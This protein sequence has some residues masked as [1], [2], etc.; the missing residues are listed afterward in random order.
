MRIAIL[1]V[2]LSLAACASALPPTET[3]PPAAP[4]AAD[5]AALFPGVD[6]NATAACVREN[7]TEGELAIMSLGDQRSQTVTA[8][9]LGRPATIACLDRAGVQLPGMP[10]S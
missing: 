9:V 5:P 7:A 2:G 6:V 3:L 8:E 4:T 10:A 1:L